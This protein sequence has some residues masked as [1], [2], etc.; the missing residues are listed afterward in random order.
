M[1]SYID[2]FENITEVLPFPLV[3]ILLGIKCT[4]GHPQK[5]EKD[6][7]TMLHVLI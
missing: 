2:Q 5:L 3:F 6:S 1:H 4:V 7:R